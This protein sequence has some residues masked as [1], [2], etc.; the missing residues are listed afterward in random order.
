M[1]QDPSPDLQQQ[2]PSAWTPLLGPAQ[3]S[4]AR[5]FNSSSSGGLWAPATPTFLPNYCCCRRVQA[6]V[7]KAWPGPSHE[8]QPLVNRCLPRLGA[9]LFSE[10]RL[11]E[12]IAVRPSQKA[13]QRE[14]WMERSNCCATRSPGEAG[15]QMKEAQM[16]LVNISSFRQAWN[17]TQTSGTRQDR[18]PCSGEV[19]SAPRLQDRSMVVE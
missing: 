10:R 4:A 12:Q 19:P 15:R 7:K 3:H 2:R 11:L 1:S 6:F 8:S 13:E 9:G 18:L 16:S 14:V 17:T 5:Y